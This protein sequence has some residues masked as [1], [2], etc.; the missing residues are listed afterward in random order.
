[1]FHWDESGDTLESSPA[2]CKV[3]RWSVLRLIGFIPSGFE[4]VVAFLLGE[5]IADMSDGLLECVVGP[6]S[7]SADQGLDLGECYLD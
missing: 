7:R 4:K 1:M 6:C 3:G 5:E 2:E